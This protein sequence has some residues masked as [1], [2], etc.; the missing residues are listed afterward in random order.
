VTV[1]HSNIIY[2]CCS[3]LSDTEQLLQLLHNDA[4][5]AEC[6]GMLFEFLHCLVTLQVAGLSRLYP[7]LVTV[8]MQWTRTVLACTQSLSLICSVSADV[9]H[10]CED[11]VRQH[12]TAQLEQGLS[13]S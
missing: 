8:A 12:V 5:E 10:G 9:R 11:E 13:V 7:H 4:V 3:F 1:K 6:V 2:F